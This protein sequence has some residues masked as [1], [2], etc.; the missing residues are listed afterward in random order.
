MVGIN[1][2]F[3]PLSEIVWQKKIIPPESQDPSDFETL[4][5]FIFWSREVLKICK[6][7][8]SQKFTKMGKKLTKN[9]RFAPKGQK[10][11]FPLKNLY[12][13]RAFRK[14]TFAKVH[15]RLSNVMKMLIFHV[16]MASPSLKKISKKNWKIKNLMLHKS[17]FLHL[18]KSNSNFF[19]ISTEWERRPDSE[20]PQ[21]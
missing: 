4:L 20:T 17:N 8:R 10:S 18:Q 11:T 14:Q 21:P 9:W 7:K 1:I 13:D 16:V 6:R 19:F 3:S 15:Y 5:T 12:S 2:K